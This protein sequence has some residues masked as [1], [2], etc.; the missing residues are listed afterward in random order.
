[1]KKVI[2]TSLVFAM[3]VGLGIALADK[4]ADDTTGNGSPK[5][6][7]LYQVNLIGMANPKNADPDTITSNGRRIFV[8]LGGK[9]RI[10]LR[11]GEF[12][13]IDYDGTDG[14]ASFQLPYPDENNDGHTAYSV[15]VRVLG[16]PGGTGSIRTIIVT[17]PGDDGII[18]TDDDETI[19]STLVLELARTKNAK[20]TNVSK[21]LLYV[22]A[23][24][25]NDGDYDR[26][27]LFDNRFEN[28]LW[29]YD[30][31]GMRLV[32]LRFYNISTDVTVDL[33]DQAPVP[34]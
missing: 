23:D 31:N 12:D 6:K 4:P 3:V 19:E 22:Y 7:K 14:L 27:P 20:F 1:M 5:V 33:P 34:E 10:L 25:D 16:K 28:Y 15:Y 17:D 9:T 8:K 30:N 32:Q 29:E 11:E 21:Y 18:G 26:V 2:I 13:V 24:V